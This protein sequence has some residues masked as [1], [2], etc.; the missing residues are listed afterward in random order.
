MMVCRSGK[1]YGFSCL[2]YCFSASYASLRI[3]DQRACGLITILARDIYICAM[4]T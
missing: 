2:T 1:D 3:T 4:Q